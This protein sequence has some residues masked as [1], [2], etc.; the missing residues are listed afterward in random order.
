M[1]KSNA[2]NPALHLKNLTPKHPSSAK[3]SNVTNPTQTTSANMDLPSG[4]LNAIST[5][6]RNPIIIGKKPVDNNNSSSASTFNSAPRRQWLHI[7]RVAPNTSVD[8]II[9]Y[10][11][12]EL[13]ITDVKCEILFSNEYICSF[14]LGVK[15]DIIKT[16]LDPAKWPPGVAVKEFIPRRTRG[17]FFRQ[18]QGHA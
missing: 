12:N 5:G 17:N 4:D 8:T 13:G 16:L 11:N 18:S 1:D 15:E 2:K 3:Q 7:G 14:K 6:Q 10:V 9:N